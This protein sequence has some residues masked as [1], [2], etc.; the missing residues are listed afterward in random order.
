MRDAA[1]FYND[2]LV[3][4]PTLGYLVAGPTTSPENM[5]YGKDGKKYSVTMGSTMST[6]IV[7]DIFSIC[8]ASA[9]ILEV[10]EAFRK[11]ILDKKSKLL[12]MRIG[13]KGQLLEWIE[14]YAEVD[15]QHRHTS[16]LYGLF[17]SNQINNAHPELMNAARKTLEIRGDGGT[18]WGIAW[19]ILFWARLQDGEHANKMIQRF[20]N[21]K[22]ALKTDYGN[23]GGIYPNMFCCHPPF[24]IDG[25]FGITAG[26]AEMLL[27]SQG[28]E[29]VLLPAMP[30]SWK[31]GEVNGLRARGGITVSIRWQECKLKEVT[32]IA[33]KTGKYSIRYGN[34]K[35][36]INLITN[37]QKT[38]KLTDFNSI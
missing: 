13:S 32:L 5:Y 22:T 37:K 25:N 16:H 2:F 33:D 21:L 36:A 24:Q 29:I 18:G 17:P 14:E 1:L 31:N 38:M 26:I 3:A 8:D 34:A 23:A 19:K 4:H 9:K 7:N 28:G 27:Q 20:F 15:P 12:P 11:Q 35:K 30:T 6:Q 10:D